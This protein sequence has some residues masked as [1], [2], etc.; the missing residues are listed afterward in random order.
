M[1]F[2]I[3]DLHPKLLNAPS[4]MVSRWIKK[5]GLPAQ[6]VAGQYHFNRAELLEWATANRGQSFAADV[7]SARRGR[8]IDP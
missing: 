7:R 3:R 5:Q 1:E 6:A 4:P 8:R 2:S